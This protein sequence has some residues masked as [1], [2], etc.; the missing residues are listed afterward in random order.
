MSAKI[1]FDYQGTHYILGYSRN[2]IRQMEAGGFI[3]DELGLKPAIRIPQLWEGAFLM[4][5]KKVKKELVNEIYKL[6]NNRDKLIPTLM[7]MYQET[8]NSLI[9]G[10]E[11]E[12]DE[13]K[14]IDW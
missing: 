3:Y 14:K 1:E 5:H 13:T 4:H 7:D 6:M 11:E 2:T 9:D 8:L 12:V 10:D